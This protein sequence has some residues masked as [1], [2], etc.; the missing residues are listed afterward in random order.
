[1]GVCGWDAD[2]A[3]WQPAQAAAPELICPNAAPQMQSKR[4]VNKLGMRNRRRLTFRGIE[5]LLTLKPGV[6]FAA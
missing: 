5:A 2:W 1:M 6:V 4:N 3:R